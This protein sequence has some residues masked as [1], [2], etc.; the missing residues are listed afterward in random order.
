[1][2]RVLITGNELFTYLQ[3]S[4][5]ITDRYLLVEELPPLFECFNH[6]YSFHANESIASLVLAKDGL[7]YAEFNALALDEAI[8]IALT[9]TDGVLVCFGGNTLLIGKTE[10]GFFAFDS[11][12]RSSSEMFS[13]S[14]K[15]TRVLLQDIKDVYSYLLNLA[16]SMGYSK[17]Y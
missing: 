17:K 1:M 11:H 12:S 14:G 8:Q 2:D 4:S 15:S 3:R 16:L 7:N 10:N 5:T 13:V 9:D 6:S